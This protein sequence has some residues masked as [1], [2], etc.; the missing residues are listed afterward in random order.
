VGAVGLGVSSN[1]FLSFALPCSFGRA[2]PPSPREYINLYYPPDDGVVQKN[3]P[4]LP[5]QYKC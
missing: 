4:G 3:S 1:F 2:P 5:R